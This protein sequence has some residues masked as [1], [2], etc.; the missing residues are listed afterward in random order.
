MPGRERLH[1]LLQFEVAAVRFVEAGGERAVI[2][3]LEDAGAALAGDA[4]TTITT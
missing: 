3:S 4:G 1:G 2:A